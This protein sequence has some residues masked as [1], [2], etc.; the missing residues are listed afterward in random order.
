MKILV[1]GEPAWEDT[2]AYG[3]TLSNF[4]GEWEDDTIY[5]FFTRN[6]APDNNIV[7]KYFMLSVYDIVKNIFKKDKGS[8]TFSRDEIDTFKQAIIQTQKKETS[9]ISTKKARQFKYFVMELIWSSGI[10]IDNKFKKFI[11]DYQ[12]EILFSFALSP[13]ILYPLISFLR[14]NTKCKVVLFVADDM[15][16]YYSNVSFLRKNLLMKSFNKCIDEADLLYGASD[17]LCAAYHQI[18]HKDFYPLVKGFHH[19]LTKPSY[20]PN[21]IKRIVYAGNLFYGRD[22]VIKRI[23]K[24]LSEL[25]KQEFQAQMEIYVG[26]NHGEDYTDLNFEDG[27]CKIYPTQTNQV[28]NRIM[29]S[30]DILLFVE[31]FEQKHIEYVH[32]SFSTKISDYLSCGKMVFVVGPEEDASI[33]YF[34]K[35]PGVEVVTNQN[36]IKCQLTKLLSLTTEE[37]INRII[38]INSFSKDN[39]NISVIRKRLRGDFLKTQQYN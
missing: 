38:Q 19:N 31:S 12:P 37:Y 4:F 39:H 35:I 13:F 33:S 16:N 6:K 3:N 34:N 18:Y 36:S 10:W 25:N 5:H 32:Y 14:K 29:C 21:K 20:H 28:I 22:K 1:F 17:S 8:K 30:A 26:T 11:C 15:L 23:A 9:D 27:S 7:S 24:E 2:N